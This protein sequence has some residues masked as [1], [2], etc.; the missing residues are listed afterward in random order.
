MPHKAIKTAF[1]DAIHHVASNI[2]AHVINPDKDLIRNRK[3]GAANLMSFMVPCGSSSTRLELLDFFGM[4]SNTPSASAF[5]QQRAKPKPEALEAVFRHF[6]SSVLDMDKKS[7]YRFL[8][9]DGS[10][11]TFFSKPSFS[12]EEYFVSEGHSAKGF[13]SM[14]LNALYNL[15]KHTYSDALIQPVHQKDEFRAFCNMVDRHDLFAATRDAFIGD[16][17]YC[18]YNNMAHVVEKNQYFLFRTKDI[19]SKGLVGKFD[20]PDT[21]SFDIQM[22][23]HQNV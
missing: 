2:S 19:H 21:E 18:S 4:N 1:S 10:T 12:S 8:A 5:N 7:G 6:N 9:A 11:F 23:F 16:R 3:I 17:G 13:Y 22:N 20:F 14:H 15:Q